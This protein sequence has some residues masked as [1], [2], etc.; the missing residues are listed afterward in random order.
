MSVEV[1]FLEDARYLRA[2]GPVVAEDTVQGTPP[3]LDDPL[4]GKP[5]EPGRVCEAEGCP[6]VLSVYNRQDLCWL[7][8]PLKF[9]T[10]RGVRKT[11]T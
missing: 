5:R 3:W 9:P 7:H 6:T 8:Q 1:T 2:G 10:Y 11:R 4:H